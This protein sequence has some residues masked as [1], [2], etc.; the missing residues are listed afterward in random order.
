[1]AGLPETLRLQALKERVY[2]AVLSYLTFFRSKIDSAQITP[3]ESPCELSKLNESELHLLDELSSKLETGLQDWRTKLQQV[4]E[5]VI[6]K[7]AIAEQRKIVL[8]DLR[9][10]LRGVEKGQGAMKLML[11]EQSEVLEHAAA[12]LRQ[13]EKLKASS[14]KSLQ[15][16][17]MQRE[18]LKAAKEDANSLAQMSLR[19]HQP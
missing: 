3:V 8:E 4:E 12:S 6:R 18:R 17:L 7:R 5:S 15:S 2:P 14:R 9:L 10:Q 19:K 11:N 13:V 1:M 16:L